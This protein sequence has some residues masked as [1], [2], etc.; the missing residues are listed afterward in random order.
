MIF[1]DLDGTLVDTAPD[2]GLALNIQRERHGLPPLDPHVIRPH[3]SHGTK[4]LLQL[5]FSCVEEDA[6][7]SA[8]RAE[9]LDI[10][11]QVCTH[12]PILFDGV[13]RV[14]QQIE[15]SGRRWGIVTNKPRRFAQPLLA[16]MQLEQRAACL[17][18]ADDAARAKP[19]PDTL[20]LACQITGARPQDCVY[21]GDAERD[22]QAGRAAGMRT[23]VALFGYIGADDCPRE[24]GADTMIQ[25]PE[26]LLAL[27]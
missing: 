15:S 25:R 27:L 9:Y 23:V 18:C 7:F 14:L 13:E 21:V 22:I 1:F 26:E 2:L 3:A 17:V 11:N 8:M 4:A 5:G 12:S 16:A 10:Y 19:F 6:E 20:H 24:W